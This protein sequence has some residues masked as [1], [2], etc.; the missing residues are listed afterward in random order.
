[1]A[2]MVSGMLF[3]CAAFYVTTSALLGDWSFIFAF[4]A[5]A[6]GSLSESSSFNSN[7]SIASN[8][9]SVSSAGAEQS[10]FVVQYGQMAATV[11]FFFQALVTVFVLAHLDMSPKD[12]SRIASQNTVRVKVVLGSFLL[13]II[14]CVIVL[15]AVDQFSLITQM[16]WQSLAVVAVGIVVSIIVGVIVLIVFKRNTAERQLELRLDFDTKLGMYSPIITTSTHPAPAA[17]V[18]PAAPATP[19]TATTTTTTTT[20]ATMTTTNALEEIDADFASQD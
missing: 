5:P 7:S 13:E 18:K 4:I 14:F 12:I 2:M 19:T 9:S 15:A 20:T 16:T 11:S 6:S 17:P 8:S 10:F 1:L 3:S